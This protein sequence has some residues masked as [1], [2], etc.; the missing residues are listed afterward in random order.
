[1]NAKFDRHIDER[2]QTNVGRFRT[3][4]QRIGDPADIDIPALHRDLDGQIDRFTNLA[5]GWTLLMINQFTLHIARYRPLVG[6]SYLQTPQSLI[7]KK[8]IVNVE[9][10]GQNCFQYAI[11]SAMF[12]AD[13]HSER[14]SKYTPH[15]D[16]VNWS[17]LT[18]PVKLPKIRLFERNNTNVTVNVYKFIGAIK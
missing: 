18:Y 4:I 5:S 1:M 17:G 7:S 8:C 11:L 13:K 15:I 6:S 10:V 2:V 16:K 3:E 14:M 9:C 12:P